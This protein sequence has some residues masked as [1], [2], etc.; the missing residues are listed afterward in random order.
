MLPQRGVRVLVR[1]RFSHREIRLR[2][3]DA[4]PPPETQGLDDGVRSVL[5]HTP[6][7]GELATQQGDDAL[8]L[9]QDKMSEANLAFL[10]AAA[11]RSH[12]GTKAGEAVNEVAL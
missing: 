4:L 2:R 11:L 9:S 12:H 1:D 5:G 7:R 3:R 6:E 10:T 8:G